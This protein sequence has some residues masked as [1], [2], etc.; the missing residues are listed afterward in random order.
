MFD[1]LNALGNT[2]WRINGQ[3][4]DIVRGVQQISFPA[5]RSVSTI[6]A[7]CNWFLCQP[8]ADEAKLWL[9]SQVNQ[10]WEFGGGQAGL[11]RRDK[12]LEPPPHDFSEPEWITP[13]TESKQEEKDEIE[14]VWK[15]E[16]RK[17]FKENRE[18]HSLCC[19]TQLKLQVAKDFQ[20]SSFYFPHNLDFRGR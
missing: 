3:L 2:R 14:V 6:A 20:N 16:L 7:D 8:F 15:R 4:F 1:G 9:R 10:L 5:V 11:V 17:V 13:L 12:T 18:R 19:D